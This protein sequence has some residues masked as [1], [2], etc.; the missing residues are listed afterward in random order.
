[1][2]VLKKLYSGEAQTD[3][4]ADD[5]TLVFYCPGCKSHHPYRIK[6]RD[7]V[8]QWNGDM[9]KP[10]ITPSLLVNG[11]RPESRCHL[12]LTDGKLIFLGDCYHELKNKTVP[13]PECDW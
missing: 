12:F 6:G 2:P 1:M 4:E 10:T 7:P 9:E 13:L 8:W 5:I 11:T 3:A